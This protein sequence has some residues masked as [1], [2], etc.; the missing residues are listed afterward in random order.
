[1]LLSSASAMVDG[2]GGTGCCAVVLADGD[3]GGLIV[4]VCCISMGRGIS[5][6]PI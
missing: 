6:T 3:F 4:S 1:M 5:Q 2:E